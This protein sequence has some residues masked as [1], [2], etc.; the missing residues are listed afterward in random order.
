M[1]RQMHS[2]KT[3]RHALASLLIFIFACFA[4]GCRND[5]EKESVRPLS[6]RDVPAQRLAFSFKPDINAATPASTDDAAKIAKVQQDFETRR[7]EEALVRGVVSPDGQRVLALY[8]TGDLQR[9]EFRIDM[10]SIEGQFL[11]NVTPPQLSCTFAP[12]VA[13][14]PDGNSIAFIARKALVPE[15]PPDATALPEIGQPAPAPS[16]GP[17]FAP[18]PAFSTE[19]IYVCDRDGFNLHPLTTRD[20]LI[21][22]HLAWA[23]DAH[24]I[25][26]LACKTEEW[27]ET[28]AARQ[29]PAG[30]PRV[31]TLDGRERLLD[32]ELKDALPVW[33]PDS[34][35]IATAYDT[36]VW[37][38][39]AATATP[40]AARIPLRDQL[41]AASAAFDA[42]HLSKNKKPGAANDKQNE[43]APSGPPKS[44][45]PIIR[46]EWAQPSSL[47]IQTGYIR[48]Y[49][50]APE[51]PRWH[52]LYLSPQA[53]LISWL[54][55]SFPI[56][57]RNAA[58][59]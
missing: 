46:L 59:C 42:Q 40:T 39:D 11:R 53:A 27:D 37:I 23:P 30:R 55:S 19:Q 14:S 34:S 25:A 33:S 20:G 21:Y 18:V 26:A 10:Y 44:F 7:T 43:A 3:I 36:D 47:L 28:E 32:D 2:G 31:L 8:E 15:Q 13:W 57:I 29:A 24:A 4:A 6:L 12:V 17:T 58:S 16:V 1:N 52:E 35:K 56:N 48:V 45:A 5:A 22:F 54:P 51:Y 38:Y 41:R 9:G 49:P 50:S